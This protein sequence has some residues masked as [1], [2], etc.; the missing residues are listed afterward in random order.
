MARCPSGDWRQAYANY[1]VQYAKFYRSEGVRI[2]DLGF[3]NE[4]DLA[5]SYA[6]MQLNPEQAV[7]MI[8]VLGPTVRRSGLPMN[9]VCCDVAGWQQQVPYTT[10]I[11][12]DRQADRLTAIHSGHVYRSRSTAPLPTDA[13][14]WMSE[15]SP[16]G[17]TWNEAWDDGSGWAGIAVAESV[18]EAFAS[19]NATGLR[20][21]VRRLPRL[22][23]RADPARR[24]GRRLPGVQAALGAG[25]LQ[26]VHPPRR[27]QGGGVGE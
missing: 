10:A 20:L 4:P 6:S 23:P 22:D 13:R 12:A 17:N 14:V 27:H 9:L 21:L 3:T 16:D 25:R 11:E 15:W 1:L 5:T 2:T 19:A 18:H 7:D 24:S 8:K 26:P